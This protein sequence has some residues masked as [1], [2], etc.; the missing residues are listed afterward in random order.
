ME[1]Q[2]IGLAAM[3][4]SV[5]IVRIL[6]NRGLLSPNEVETIYGSMIEGFSYGGREIAAQMGSAVEPSFADFCQEAK[7][8]WIG[9]EN[10]DPEVPRS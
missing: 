4:A 7:K 6:V 3:W 9:R 5:H 1:D 2:G 10:G 8:R